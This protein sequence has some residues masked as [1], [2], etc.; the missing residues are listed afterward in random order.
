MVAWQIGSSQSIGAI[1]SS[2]F[3]VF[4]YISLWFLFST[5]P[6]ERQS[7]TNYLF[8]PILFLQIKPLLWN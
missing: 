5:S 1:I 2:D 3:L 4:I 7:I 8:C 6:R